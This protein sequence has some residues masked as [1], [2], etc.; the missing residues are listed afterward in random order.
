MTPDIPQQSK[1]P[2]V[3]VV[4]DHPDVRLALC[5]LLR[6]EGLD[7]VEASSPE[8]ACDV[9]MRRSLSCAVVDLN[10]SADTTSGHE[11]MALVTRLRG[12]VPDVPLVVMTAWGSI[13]LAVEAMRRGAADFV[14]KPWNRNRMLNILWSQVRLHEAREENRRLRAETALHREGSAVYRAT[15]SSAM[16]RVMELVERITLG[17]SHVLVLGENG[18]GKS[19]LARDI[20]ARSR[21]VSGLTCSIASTPCKYASRRCGS[22]QKTSCRWH[23]ISCCANAAAWAAMRR[24]LHLPPNAPCVRMRGPATSAN[25]SMRWNARC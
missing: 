4:D 1:Y 18:T 10:Y 6:G 19:M 17:E 15:E 16:R 21:A 12:L 22:G 13:N 23:G 25:W 3:L 8:A 24:A 7:A 2:P 5:M 14:E 9:A 20:H 11:G